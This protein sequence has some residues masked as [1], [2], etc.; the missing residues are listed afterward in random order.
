MKKLNVDKTFMQDLE[1]AFE[2]NSSEMRHFLDLQTGEIITLS[3]YDDDC[4]GDEGADKGLQK[5]SLRDEI[6]ED[7]DGR[8]IPIPVADSREA[9]RDMEDFTETITDDNLKE[10]LYIALNGKGCFRRFKDV[11]LNYPNENE[12][13]FQ[14]KESKTRERIKDWLEQENIELEMTLGFLNHKA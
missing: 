13:W 8:Y 14:F 12:K 11:L 2:N 9:Y 10:K 1:F 7:D 5:I 3:D 4:W 6:D